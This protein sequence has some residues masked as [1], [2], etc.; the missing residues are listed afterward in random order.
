MVEGLW[1]GASGTTG[2]VG[3]GTGS[4]TSRARPEVPGVSDSGFRQCEQVVT[5]LL[6]VYSAPQWGHFGLS[7]GV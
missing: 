5:M 7:I 3:G 6:G 4:E 2:G 1:G